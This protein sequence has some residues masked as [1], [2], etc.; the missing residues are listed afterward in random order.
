MAV[1]PWH[2]YSNKVEWSSKDFYDDFKLKKTFYLYGLYTII[3][4]YGLIEGS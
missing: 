1:D 4:F 3:S 2:G